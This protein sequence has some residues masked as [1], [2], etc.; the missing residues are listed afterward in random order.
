MLTAS[1]GTLPLPVPRG[2]TLAGRKSEA[3]RG[4]VM[5]NLVVAGFPRLYKPGI[6]KTTA[7]GIPNC[8]PTLARLH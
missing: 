4:R 6:R 8:I 3:G 5:S 2:W 7:I 1:W